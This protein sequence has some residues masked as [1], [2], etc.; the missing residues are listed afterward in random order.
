MATNLKCLHL[1]KRICTK[2]KVQIHK[3]GRK[4][5]ALSSFPSPSNSFSSHISLDSFKDCW[6]LGWV[7]LNF[8]MHMCISSQLAL[9][10]EERFPLWFSVSRFYLSLNSAS[11]LSNFMVCKWISKPYPDKLIGKETKRT[12]NAF[13]SLNNNFLKTGGLKAY[14]WQFWSC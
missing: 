7:F 13:L 8:I 11:V 14:R 1:R 4:A 3:T 9:S 6:V 12:Q 5:C 10:L 2:I